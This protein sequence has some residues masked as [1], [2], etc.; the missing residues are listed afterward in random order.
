M[1]TSLAFTGLAL[2]VGLSACAATEE[3]PLEANRLRATGLEVAGDPKVD[4]RYPAIMTY[5]VN[6]DVRVIESCFSW[7]GEDDGFPWRPNGPYCFGPEPGGGAEAVTAM[8]A[9]GYPGTYRLEGYVRY[10]GDGVPRNSNRVATEIT[11]TPRR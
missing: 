7:S 11:V 6:G 10:V 9:T 5:D 1:R 2:A 8:L 3:G 4:V